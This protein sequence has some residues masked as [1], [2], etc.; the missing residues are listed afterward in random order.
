MGGWIWR[1]GWAVCNLTE[2]N[3]EKNQTE[4]K[5][6]E[7]CEAASYIGTL[8]AGYTE[9]GY[10]GRVSKTIIEQEALIGVS[11]TGMHANPLSFS[12]NLY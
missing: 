10:L 4:E 8:Q 6:F 2:I 5:F 3:M 12:F 7:A 9:T 11:L 1:S